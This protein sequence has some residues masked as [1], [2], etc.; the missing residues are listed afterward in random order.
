MNV[1]SDFD[2]L[3]VFTGENVLV[4]RKY[5][6]KNWVIASHGV[7]NFPSHGLEKNCVC[8]GRENNKVNGPN[9]NNW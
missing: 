4:L 5:L 1:K 2:D 7:C 8:G 6:L 3:A 9:I